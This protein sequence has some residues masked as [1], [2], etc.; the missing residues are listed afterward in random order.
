MG[1]PYPKARHQARK[2]T[3]S[4]RLSKIKLAGFK[5][6]VDPTDVYLPSNLIGVVGPNG[7][8]KSNI[9][10]AVRWVMGETSAKMLRGA[11]MTDVIFSGSATRKPVG[12]AMV[13]LVFD[14]SD[15]T[16]K[17]E[18]AK[19][20]EISVK[21]QVTRDG[22]S[23]YFL[24]GSKCR[25]KD[26]VDLFL[27][28]GLG[29]RSYAIIE[30]GMISRVVE[31]R[32]EELR[33]YIEEAAGISR[34]RERRRETE[35]RIR[36][37]RENLER[38]DDVRAELG[39]RLLHLQRQ[40]K[41][42][43]RYTELKEQFRA[44]EAQLLALRWR[45]WRQ[46]AEVEAEKA[47]SME[48]EL[49]KIRAQLTHLETELDKRR[50]AHYQLGEEANERQENLYQINAR[51]GKI[52]QAIQY[53]QAMS[54]RQK[55]ELEDAEKGIQQATD[56]LEQDKATLQALEKEITAAAP[57]LAQNEARLQ[58]QQ[59][60]LETL[61]EEI[62]SWQED[63]NQL[64]ASLAEKRR[65]VEVEKT[66]IAAAEEQ[67]ARQTRRL[68]QLTAETTTVSIEPLEKEWRHLQAQA[69]EAQKQLQ[70]RM[71]QH[72]QM[73]EAQQ[74]T[75]DRL[76][77]LQDRLNQDQLAL[78]QAKG[79]RGSL[80][81]LQQ[82]ALGR[83]K[84]PR[85]KWLNQYK[86][87]DAAVLASMLDVEPG[88]ETAVEVVLGERLQSIV[89]EQASEAL[90]EAMAHWNAGRLTL[91]EAGAGDRF[92]ARPGSLAAFVQ[93]PAVVLDWL[94]DV[95]VAT[96]QAD[97][98]ARRSRL[99]VSASVITPDGLWLGRNWLHVNKG[100][101]KAG[102]LLRKKELA[103][104]SETI[105]ALEEKIAE[106]VDAI[107]QLRQ[108]QQQQSQEADQLQLD[109]NMR[110]RR[111]A[112]LA[113]QA[114]N[115]QHK[116]VQLQ[117][118]QQQLS[119]EASQ[120]QKQMQADDEQIKQARGRLEEALLEVEEL[121]HLR[122]EQQQY[123]QGLY[124][125]RNTLRQ[126]I[127]DLSSAFYQ[128][129]MLN[130][131]KKT[132][133]E[134]IRQG[135]LRLSEQLDQWQKRRHAVL[136]QLH[137]ASA[138]QDNPQ[139]ELN[140]LLASRLEAET[141]RDKARQALQDSQQQMDEL[142]KQRQELAQQADEQRNRLESARL[143]EQSHA[144]KANAF[145]EQ[146]E[147]S[148]G[149][150]K[151][152]LHSMDENV[153]VDSLE[154]QLEQLQRQITRLEPVNLAAISEYEEEAK[155]KAY[156]DE[157]NADLLEALETLETAIAKI[158]KETRALFRETFDAVNTNIQKLFPK[159]FGGGQA[160]LELTGDDLLTTGVSIM[161]RPPGKRV[162]SIQLLSG[163]EKALTAVSLVFSIFNLNPAPFCLLDEVDAPL[164]DA[165]VGR[166][167]QMVKEMSEKVQFVFV[168]HNKVT[169]EIANQLLGVT[170]REPGVSR[171]VSVDLAEAEKLASQTVSTG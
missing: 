83:E 117:Q 70:A 69:E 123:Q 59:L 66:R 110:H 14:N 36:H 39:K 145:K 32:P 67:M 9:I 29:P 5:S 26:I 78:H 165:N 17:G 135:M 128:Q 15:G 44:I 144:M 149:A 114:E 89:T 86:L 166:F 111:L 167:S 141:A 112:E 23:S 169:M 81:A 158:D 133:A 136:Q 33:A 27:G 10:D 168:T 97:A 101:A 102:F 96:D 71:E 153:T 40:A 94:N 58:E 107:K 124:D 99:E 24:N 155:R 109:V 88:W 18:F 138:K 118:R 77:Q 49:E 103:E 38:L 84:G 6:F 93:G 161:A 46:H 7:C 37:T 125:K 132:Q 116:I 147:N 74:Q 143:S 131:N 43:E 134:S 130:Q 90:I 73:R 19:Y 121:E 21:R 45:Q 20:N 104:L 3:V 56:Q 53:A 31:S 150:L 139:D 52:E 8:G 62:H 76:R 142:E 126:Q 48:T 140:A 156:L 164:D 79:R 65:I 28:T 25:K 170:M 64:N 113:S 157:Q 105:E 160:Y 12:S 98:L 151:E 50:V 91:V 54:E 80:E 34:Y 4:M 55:R 13:E 16:I 75:A 30:Q 95:Q 57:Q 35:N 60:A 87:D 22:Q 92:S 163:G 47:R 154:R 159:L 2:I 171:L 148:G 61:E 11:S 127:N 115:R 122:A 120:L 72:A 137:E 108:Q 42:A 129:K 68:D 51:I 106:T 1:A 63:W 41:N 152:I 100:D 85:Q 119:E 146:L 82:A 162:S